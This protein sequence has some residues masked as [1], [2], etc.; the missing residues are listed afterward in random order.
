[1]N[2]LGALTKVTEDEPLRARMSQEAQVWAQEQFC[3]SARLND[4]ALK[5][6]ELVG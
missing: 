6:Q 5:I 3:P 4:Y 2:F 1:M